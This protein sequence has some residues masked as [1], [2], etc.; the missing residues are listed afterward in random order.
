MK[1]SL[2]TL[3]MLFDESGRFFSKL[4]KLGEIKMKALEVISFGRVSF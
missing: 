4:N 3:L 1:K 2:V